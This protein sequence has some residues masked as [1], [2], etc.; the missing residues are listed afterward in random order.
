MKAIVYD[1]YGPPEVERVEEVEAPVPGAGQLLVRVRAT[2]VNRSDCHR[3]GGYPKILRLVF[4]FPRPRRRVL[5]MEFAGVIEAVGSAVHGFAVG[6]AVFGMIW[7]GAHAELL[8]VRADRL[9]A[10]KPANLSF[11][12]A[13]AVPDGAQSAMYCLRGA[14][15]AAGMDV[16]VFGASGSIGIATVQLAKRLGARVTAVC[17]TQNVELIRSLGADEVLDY[18]KGEDFTKRLGAYDVVVDAVGKHSFLRARPALKPGGRYVSAD[19]GINLL[20][21][22]ITRFAS[23]RVALPF[24]RA[25]RADILSLKDQ[26]EAGTYRPVIDRTYRL[27]DIVEAS[28]YV[29]TLQKTGSI[30]LTVDGEHTT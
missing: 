3:R 26:L 24:P 27:E 25:P 7:S 13:A 6:D 20:L 28:R 10:H 9:V 16:L 5:G 18:T 12:Q 4:G 1:R 21:A 17:R 29:E 30:V 15:V 22:P 2:T 8:T 11:E 19:G 14:R 23:K